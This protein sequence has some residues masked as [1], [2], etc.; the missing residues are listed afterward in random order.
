MRV[1]SFVAIF[2][3]LLVH[4]KLI[5]PIFWYS[6]EKLIGLLV[7]VIAIAYE[8]IRIVILESSRFGRIKL[9]WTAKKPMKSRAITNDESQDEGF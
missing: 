6:D 7:L 4:F 9:K 5:Y 8:I 1:E 2:I 3:I